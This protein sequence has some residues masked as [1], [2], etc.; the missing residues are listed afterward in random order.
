MKKNSQHEYWVTILGAALT[1]RGLPISP[2]GPIWKCLN[3]FQY[4]EVAV[5][6]WY[7]IDLAIGRAS[8]RILP[9]LLLLLLS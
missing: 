9:I 8:V 6:W 4:K 5:V 2:K 7:H 1:K 3:N